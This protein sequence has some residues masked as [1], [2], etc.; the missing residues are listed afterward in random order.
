M[1]KHQLPS[2]P[3]MEQFWSEL[4]QVFSWLEVEKAVP[5][6]VLRSY[7]IPGAG[8]ALNTSWRPPVMVRSWGGQPIEI[9]RYAAANH[10]LVDL[11]Y[12]NKS[13]LVEPY[14]L[15]QTK[16][17]NLLLMAVKHRS[18]EPRSYR[19]DRIQG[20]T[21]TDTSFAPRYIIE[22]TAL[23]YQPAPHLSRPTP[24]PRQVRGIRTG[25]TYKYR[26]SIC[27]KHFRKTTFD[28]TLRRH[29]HKTGA[30]CFGTL[31]IYEGTA[32]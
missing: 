13:R 14:S 27:G 16:D 1:L 29:K 11:H 10:L 31:G 28:P 3:P 20:A 4:P 15:R 12:D 5:R 7:P 19:V 8:P 6:P 25:L 18:G 26:C 9:I 22:L 2:L 21:V 23:G 17:G 24:A 30:A 32:R